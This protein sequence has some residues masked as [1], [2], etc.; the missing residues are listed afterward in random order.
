MARPDAVALSGFDDAYGAASRLREAGRDAEAAAAF[1]HLAS[2]H[3]DDGRACH[4]LGVCYAEGAGVPRDA[5]AAVYWWREGAAKGHLRSRHKLGLAFRD[6]AGCEK[7]EEKARGLLQLAAVRWRG[8]ATCP[9]AG[10]RARAV[11][12][13]EYGR[14]LLRGE[15]RA[16]PGEDAVVAAL[17]WLA[18]AAGGGDRAAADDLAALGWRAPAATLVHI[19]ARRALRLEPAVPA[20]P[21][22][23]GHG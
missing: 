11:A 9:A 22:A 18:D 6:G 2:R 8:V 15:A 7:D 10:A 3:D 12:A 16:E 19:A 5:A 21:S 20:R 4:A 17:T 14:M 13:R 1:L 23:G